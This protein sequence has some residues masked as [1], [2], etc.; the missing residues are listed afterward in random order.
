MLITIKEFN[1][2]NPLK[3][4]ADSDAYYVKLANRIYRQL[5]SGRDI[6]LSIYKN[7]LREIAI[8]TVKYFEDV[9]SG[10]GIWASF[11]NAH[12]SLYGKKLPFYDVEEDTYIDDEINIEDIKYLIWSTVV[13]TNENL[14]LNP[15]SPGVEGVAELIYNIFDEEF[16]KAPINE[17][18]LAV[19]CD[20]SRYVDFMKIKPILSWLLCDCYLISTS[21]AVDSIAELARDYAENFCSDVQLAFYVAMSH[22][23]ITYKTGPL[24]LLPQHWL[25]LL[26]EYHKMGLMARNIKTIEGLDF[27][28]FKN[29]KKNDTTIEVE[30]T[31]GNH[32]TVEMDSFAQQSLEDTLSNPMLIMQLAKFGR[33]WQLNGSCISTKDEYL[34]EEERK[35]W[36]DSENRKKS[37][38]DYYYK[39][40]NG[41]DLLFFETYDDFQ[42][43]MGVPATPSPE[44]EDLKKRKHIAVYIDKDGEPT[45][46]YSNVEAISSPDNPFYDEQIAT[47][48]ALGMLAP[49]FSPS[50]EFVSYLVKHGLLKDASINTEKGRNNAIV[51]ENIDFLTRFLQRADYYEM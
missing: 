29:K 17:E 8:R 27:G 38:H 26:L 11:R 44:L 19:L 7:S 18:V 1:G 46:I 25:A 2:K 34:F 13:E 16:E 51:Q 31:A 43:W 15:H 50:P 35:R 37:I 9:I 3:V 23:S 28:V 20:A 32:Y 30:S 33:T 36:E 47:E 21:D 5:K 4:S 40:A 14:I 6:P 45:I 41:K 24:A 42:K 22:C 10:I 49:D 12:N 48:Y 39:K